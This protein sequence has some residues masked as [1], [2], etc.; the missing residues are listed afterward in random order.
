MDNELYGWGR[1]DWFQIG[2]ETLN[3]IENNKPININIEDKSIKQISCG[4]NHTLVLTSDGMVYGWGSNGSGQIGC[5]KELGSKDINNLFDI[6]T[7]N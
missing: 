7:D 3:N 2:S 5:G 4:Y 6:I 1:N